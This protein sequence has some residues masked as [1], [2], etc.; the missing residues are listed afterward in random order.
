MGGNGTT[1]QVTPRPL[2]QHLASE[3]LK[4]PGVSVHTASRVIGAEL[5]SVSGRVKQ[6]TLREKD[7]HER[8]VESTDLV[9]AAG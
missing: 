6:I 8:S 1:A 9:I 7:G 2:V 3:A 4:V 5:D